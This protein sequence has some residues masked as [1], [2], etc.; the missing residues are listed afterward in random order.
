MFD[1]HP[2]AA[3]FYFGLG[4]FPSALTWLL[5]Y[6]AACVFKERIDG[7]RKWDAELE[8]YRAQREAGEGG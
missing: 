6:M 2:G 1:R 3:I 8:E 5:F 7:I 4:L